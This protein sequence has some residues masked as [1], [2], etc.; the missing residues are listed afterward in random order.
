[1]TCDQRAL[2]L[3]LAASTVLTLFILAPPTRSDDRQ[4]RAERSEAQ[5]LAARLSSLWPGWTPSV[6]PQNLEAET[7]AGVV[8][9]LVGP[10]TMSAEYRV[11]ARLAGLF[12]LW[13][14]STLA[15]VPAFV[16]GEPPAPEPW[17]TKAL[18]SVVRDEARLLAEALEA[19]KAARSRELARALVKV[20]F[21]RI[22]LLNDR[23]VATLR[24]RELREG[25]ALYTAYHGLLLA[26]HPGYA[27]G[28]EIEA[29]LPGFAYERAPALRQALIERLRAASAAGRGH[30][31]AAVSGF[32]LALLLDRTQHGW[33]EQLLETGATLDALL[34]GP[35]SD[36]G[37]RQPSA[38]GRREPR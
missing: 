33:R 17:A 14:R 10:A 8:Q 22:A 6:S 9:E 4:N 13:A 1:M 26:R 24:H 32:G 11:A 15:P 31:D 12:A 37:N 23:E 7:P 36:F 20:R 38:A 3:V 21:R 28:H 30:Y 27:P 16:D 25:L 18:V 29:A 5:R 2:S 19:A 35:P 34:A